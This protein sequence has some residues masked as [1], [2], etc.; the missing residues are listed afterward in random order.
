MAAKAAAAAN[1]RSKSATPSKA[2]PAK[3]TVPKAAKKATA[4]K[5]SATK[6]SS[7][8]RKKTARARALG[9]SPSQPSRW[10]SGKESPSPEV[11]RR[12]I[13]LDHVVARA[14]LVWHPDVVPVWL[15]SSNQHLYGQSPLGVL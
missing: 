3:K 6:R 2:K 14:K 8:P 12:L 5:K 15:R 13:D 10:R 9:V 7:V 1:S 4:T 11:E